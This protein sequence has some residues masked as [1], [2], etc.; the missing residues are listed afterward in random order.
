[1]F[2]NKGL[3][4]IEVIIS[5]AII[6]IIT[7]GLLTASNSYISMIFDSKDIT[8]ELMQAQQELEL[9]IE[10][11]KSTIVSN[12][13]LPENNK[14]SI[15]NEETFKLFEN[16]DGF[17][18]SITGY[19]RETEL[20]AG[21]VKKLRTIIT[22]NNVEYKVANASDVKIHFERDNKTVEDSYED[23]T[24][25]INAEFK[26][27]DTNINYKNLSRWYVS[28]EGFNI[29]LAK[30]DSENIIETEIGTKYPR[31]P[32]DYYIIP[33][34]RQEILNNIKS[35]YAGKH[36]IYTVTPAAK[37]GKMGTT[38]N[39]N[40]VFINGL[41]Y[42][43]YL[44]LHLDASM[45]DQTSSSIIRK[46]G[47]ELF[48][49][50]WNDLST[51]KNNAQ[52][53][54]N[55]EQPRFMHESF[56]TVEGSNGLIYD[57]Y[58]NFIRFSGNDIIRI[59][60]D[61]S[62]DN[63]RFTIFAVI[64]TEENSSNKSIISK[65]GNNKGWKLGRDESGNYNIIL[66]DGDDICQINATSDEG[67]DS[68]WHIIRI[69][70][71]GM[72]GEESGDL[73]IKIDDATV[74]S[75][76]RNFNSI[77]NSA[78]LVIDAGNSDG[79]V[80]IAEV[81]LYGNDLSE[82]NKGKVEDYLMKKYRPEPPNI[83]IIAL[84]NIEKNVFIGNPFTM[85]YYARA[86]LSNG[87]KR[88][89]AVKWNPD[90]IDTSISGQYTFVGTAVS[91]N[92]KTT[93]MTVN[94]ITI[95]HIDNLT[96][97]VEKGV[98][99]NPPETV[100]AFFTDG[101]TY[102]IDNIVWT[103]KVEKDK[104]GIYELTGTSGYMNQNGDKLSFKL[105]VTVVPVKV[106]LVSIEHDSIK[107]Y[108]GEDYNL[109]ATVFP[110][111]VDN[112]NLNWSSSNIG[113]ATV[114]LKD[115]DKGKV[116][117]YTKGTTIIKVSTESDESVYDTCSVEILKPA[118]SVSIYGSETLTMDINETP[119]LIPVFKDKNASIVNPDGTGTWES[120]HED[121][122]TVDQHG[123]ITT[124]KKGDTDIEYT[125]TMTATDYEEEIDT[126]CK[127]TVIEAVTGLKDISDISLNIGESKE[128]KLEFEP[129]D[130]S[131]VNV[132]CTSQKPSVAE[133]TKNSNG[134][135]TIK[136]KSKGT[137]EISVVTEDGGY[138]KTFSVTVNGS[139][140]DILEDALAQINSFEMTAETEEPYW[141]NIYYSTYRIIKLPNSNDGISFE[142]EENSDLYLL[143]D[144][145]D[146]WVLRGYSIRKN[147]HYKYYPNKKRS[148]T[149]TLKATY[150]S[151]TKSKKFIVTIP[152]IG[153]GP[154][155][156][157]P[158]N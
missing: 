132:S 50:K 78:R 2:N 37:S 19:I 130:P 101:N 39:S 81:I 140:E 156:I 153:N 20:D 73:T 79:Y 102:N 43:E 141:N 70:S 80:D 1:M 115:K 144:S 18:R 88:E 62:L 22:D 72:F 65:Y 75:A 13:Y 146:C 57:T 95:D 40:S 99:Y 71:E 52:Q 49:K 53:N 91:D 105:T 149:L 64:R 32:D 51:K 38:I 17:E 103:G 94:V 129:E 30:I 136:G 121:I 47:D 68:E 77:N 8:I 9:E 12:T 124:H 11:V 14:I 131:N 128:I 28:R 158:K 111:K 5:I 36:I 69:S 42:T 118:Q 120:K 139:D 98:K 21:A 93:N 142:F 92:T 110:E 134:K 41:P 24:L 25:S 147:G 54:T 26:I 56:G 45:L 58:A 114:E 44:K 87:T 59:D 33:N 155:T 76:E 112:K 6:G 74:Y 46:S 90:T 145:N 10:K 63:E 61:N 109:K 104:L 133:I 67:R 117:A 157:A 125:F 27:D 122:A 15:S 7:S 82:L 152:K 108:E 97:I 123:N 23:S 4:M 85:P 148:V 89:I 60:D 119:Q 34:E 154:I 16:E 48:I 55:S 83:N 107:V 143:L 106:S 116:V 84:E 31:F 100:K 96:D 86:I 137:S 138:E 113:F 151:I 150:N 135:I 126:K 127:V 66:G 3:T 35:E 29:P